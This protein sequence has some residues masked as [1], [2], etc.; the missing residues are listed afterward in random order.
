M[1]RLQ[2]ILRAG[3]RVL[4]SISLVQCASMDLL[5]KLIS[6]LLSILLGLIAVWIGVFVE[7]EQVKQYL[8]G[9]PQPGPPTPLHLL[10]LQSQTQNYK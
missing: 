5:Y 8:L 2:N 7:R 1:A 3:M 4:R 10:V 6:L 9:V